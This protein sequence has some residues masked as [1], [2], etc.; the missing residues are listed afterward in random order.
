MGKL[1]LCTSKKTLNVILNNIV[2]FSINKQFE[3]QCGTIIAFHKLRMRNENVFI[4]GEDF[5]VGIGTYI[6]NEKIG[7]EALENIFYDYCDGIREKIIGS[8]CLVICKN[9]RIEVFVDRLATYNMYYSIENG[10][11]ILTNTYFH[12]ALGKEKIEIDNNVLIGRWLK[13]F[14]NNQTPIKGVLKLL[15][16]EKLICIGGEWSLKKCKENFDINP[17][18][19]GS[20]VSIARDKYSVLKKL[21]DSFGIFMT[22]GQDSRLSLALL[23]SLGAKPILYYGIGNSSNTV[24]KKNDFE[25]VKKISELHSLKLKLMNWKESDNDSIEKYVKKY[26]ELYTLY[27][28]NKNIFNE[29]ESNIDVAIVFFGYFGEVYRTIES[30]EAFKNYRFNLDDFVD[31]LYISK[32]KYLMKES[33]Y[34]DFYKNTIKKQFQYVCDVNGLDSKNLSKNDFQ[35]L[36]TVYRT[37]Y[38][39]VMNN[40]ANQ[41]VYS[42]PLFGDYELIRIVERKDYEIKMNARYILQCIEEMWPD[43]LKIPFF[44]HIKVKKYDVV[45]KELKSSSFIYDAKDWIKSSINNK[46]CLVLARYFYYLLKWDIKGLKETNNSYKEKSSLINNR[47]AIFKISNLDI[48]K[49]EELCDIRAL[50]EFTLLNKMIEI[51]KNK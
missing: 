39:T 20:I 12:V 16:D 26:G 5:V 38:D 35:I 1:L 46:Y 49:M 28:F 4:M 27:R 19:N 42:M 9:N 40:F 22:G 44:S 29:F 51:L 24:T 10:E 7:K 45:T 25:I 13:H 14:I 32:F 17:L 37:H 50:K 33:Y 2:D 15:G 8:Y 3:C 23:L 31:D 36:N 11:I 30:I 43:L 47:R 48:D 6:Y 34:N 21:Y 18:K 41:F